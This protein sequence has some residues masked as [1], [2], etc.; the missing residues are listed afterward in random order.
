MKLGLALGYSGARLELPLDLIRLAE[1]LGYDSLWTAEAY[2]SDAVTPL[3]Y[4]AARTER[5]RLGTGIM[6]LAGRTPAM[7]AMQAQTVDALAGGG[8]FIAGLGVSGP[9]IVEGWYG[10]PWGKPY[11]RLRD[12]IKIMRKVFARDE[13]VSHDGRE[14]SLPYEGPGSTGLGKPLRSIMHTN[15][16]L[17]IWLGSGSEATVKLTAE[18][19]DGWLPMHFVPGRMAQYRPWVEEGFRRA[20][21]GK[22]WA[23]FEVQA[24]VSVR[25][26]DDVGKALAV[27]KPGIALYV[28]G[29]GHSSVN[30][31]NQHM[32]QMGYVDVAEQI[33]RLYLSGRKDEAIAVVPDDYVDERCL[34]GS[35]ERIR[36]RYAAW[37]DS[38]ATG[39]TVSADQPEA[40]ELMADIARERP[41]VG[42]AGA[43]SMR[44]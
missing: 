36:E 5:I 30:F 13:P 35:P 24:M 4:L 34:V 7:C 40:L 18:L 6:Q 1:R 3:A 32:R 38:G 29:M 42:M 9:Q 16:R 12:Y 33:Q 23:D 43:A 15:P 28:G 8:R 19:C 11:W 10:E 31:H 21:G 20:G 39:L 27:Q 14:I 41:A 44:S 25:L 37:A 17:P 26:T 22:G 2:G